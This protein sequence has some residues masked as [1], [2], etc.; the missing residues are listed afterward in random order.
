MQRNR[1]QIPTLVCLQLKGMERED[2]ILEILGLAHKYGFIDLET[3]I[4]DFLRQALTIENCCLIY[5]SARLYNLRFLMHVSA[6]FVDKHVTKI[7]VHDSFLQLSLESVKSLISRDSFFAPEVDIFQAVCHWIQNNEVSQEEQLDVLSA[8]RLPLMTFKDL[9]TIVRPTGLLSPEAILDAIETQTLQNCSNKINHRGLL[10]PELNMASLK[11][12]TAVLQGE[13]KSALLDGNSLNYDMERGYTRH[14]IGTSDDPGILI[15]LGT[16]CI[17]NHIKILLWD[18]D[19][20]S[21]SYYIEVSINQNDWIRVVDYTKYYCRS[22]QYL[23]F[24][25]R[26]VRF[27]RIVGTN[28]TVNKV[29]HV[30]SFEIMYTNK[31]FCLEKG[32]IVPKHNVATNSLSATI[33]EGVSRTRNSLLDGNTQFYDW[34]SGYTCHQ[35]GSG[36]ILIQLGQPYLIDSMRLLLWDCDDRLY[37]YFIEVSVNMWDW[38]LII[39][40]SHEQCTSW[41]TLYFEKRPVVFIRI[42][43]TQNTANEVFHLVH[44]ECPAQTDETPCKMANKSRSLLTVTTEIEGVGR[45]TEHKDIVV[46]MEEIVTG[47]N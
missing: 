5:D 8:V 23:Y 18:K 32:L 47:L 28:N 33:I 26:V 2:L 21:Y 1:L 22:W 37:S 35:L 44:F 30:V 12:G 29:F 45:E 46:K 24:E 9:L 6:V 3:A 42:T 27:I 39:D 43:G 20:R 34:E 7:I 15:K 10:Q 4:S 36:C 31:P 13:M 40:K 14:S 19:L 17:V 25:P 38:D 16:Q 11:Q 41:Q